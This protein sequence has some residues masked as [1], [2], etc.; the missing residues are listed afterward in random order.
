MTPLVQWGI[1]AH[2]AIEGCNKHQVNYEAR[3]TIG[4]KVASFGTYL[5]AGLAALKVATVGQEIAAEKA[6]TKEAAVDSLAQDQHGPIGTVENKSASGCRGVEQTSSGN[7]EAR[8][9]VGGKRAGFGTYLVVE[10]A[11]LQ[12]VTIEQQEIAAEEAANKN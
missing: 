2:L 1:R 9:A 11:A 5:A 10:L 12:V 4:G 6:A 8:S 3:P 7:Y